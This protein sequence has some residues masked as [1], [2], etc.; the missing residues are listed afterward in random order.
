[1]KRHIRFMAVMLA[2]AIA[3]T[4][5]SCWLLEE[6]FGDE[7]AT[8][9]AT[10]ILWD[11]LKTAPDETYVFPDI[12]DE[13]APATRLESDTLDMPA[14]PDIRTLYGTV[15]TYPEEI[16]MEHVMAVEVYM[17]GKRQTVF[18]YVDDPSMDF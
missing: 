5:T 12:P 7:G 18:V 9:T 8:E 16:P 3:A 11:P 2:L 15:V 6:P 13:T 17:D 10:D 4:L 1:M 14:V